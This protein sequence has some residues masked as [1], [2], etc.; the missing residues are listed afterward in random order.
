LNCVPHPALHAGVAFTVCDT[1]QHVK[2][3]GAGSGQAGCV[4]LHVEEGLVFELNNRL[5]HNVVNN[6]QQVGGR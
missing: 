1:K 3:G 6:G 4:P 2:A 5:P